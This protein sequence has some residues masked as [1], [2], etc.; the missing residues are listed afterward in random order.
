MSL[1]VT[2]LAAFDGSVQSW[3]AAVKEAAENHAKSLAFRAFNMVIE[4]SPQYSGQFA[5]N[6]KIAYGSPDTSFTRDPLNT[7]GFSEPTYSVGATPA[8]T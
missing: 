7:K 5:A 2:N 8:K 4:T 3:F 6:W 1:R